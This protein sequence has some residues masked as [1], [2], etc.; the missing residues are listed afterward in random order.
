[1]SDDREDDRTRAEKRLHA[2]WERAIERFNRAW[3]AVR[4]ERALCME[5]RRF[6][7]IAGAQWEGPEAEHFA[8]KPKFEFNK[9]HLAVVRIVSEY[10]NNRVTVDFV[11]PDDSDDAA[12]K[13]ADLCDG[14]YRSTEQDS[15]ADEAY[16]LAHEEAVSGG[17]G[18]WELTWGYE[19]ELDPENEHQT[20]RIEPISDADQWVLFDDNARR[21]DKSD[22]MWAFRMFPMSKEAFEEEFG[23]SPNDWPAEKLNSDI[24]DWTPGDRVIVAAYYEVTPKRSVVQTWTDLDGVETRYTDEDFENDAELLNTLQAIGSK[25]TG[26]RKIKRRVVRKYLLSGG[27]GLEDCGQVPGPN[28]PIVVVYGKRWVVDGVERCMGHVRLAKDAQR[29]KNM[30]VSKLGEIAALSAVEKPILSPEQIAG[31]EDTWAEDSVKNYPYALLNVMRDPVTGAMLPPQPMGYTKPPQ[32]PP[33]MAALLQL[34]EQD[35]QDILGRDQDGEKMA[36]N[37]SGKT[38]DLIQQRL[39]MQRFVY[40]SNFAKAMKRS[41]EVWLGMAKE[42]FVEKGRKVRVITA[43]DTTQTRVLAQP[44]ADPKTKAVQVMNDLSRADFKVIVDVGPS[45]SSKRAST[46][47]ALTGMVTMTQDPETVKVLTS[48]AIHNLEGEGMAGLRKWARKQL[49]AMGA[50]EPTDAERKEMAQVQQQPD[51]NAVFL[52]AEAEKAGAMATKARAD[53]VLAVAKSKETEARTAEILAAIPREE[54]ASLI[55]AAQAMQQA[56]SGPTDQPAPVQ[57]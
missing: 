26:E 15:A 3:P 36:S 33:A 5:D 28:I 9:V 17:M 20:I 30:Q 23:Q 11:P 13:L 4:D 43:Q 56:P 54:L 21:A 29:L 41:G 19:D 34:T 24:Y 7:S 2:V 47:R 27:A 35:M 52:M 42:L 16:D 37:I 31:H 48:A 25:K 45:T 14:L 6:Y 18:A 8:N 12:D 10:R 50:E 1:M 49:I 44:V 51:P 39:D 46:V 57:P 40:Q 22:A 38:V 32:I 55:A 53:T